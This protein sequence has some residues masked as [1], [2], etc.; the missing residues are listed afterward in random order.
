MIQGIVWIYKSNLF[1]FFG[2][3][4]FSYPMCTFDVKYLSINNETMAEVEKKNIKNFSIPISSEVSSDSHRLYAILHYLRMYCIDT[5][6]IAF[7]KP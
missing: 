1:A 5:E 4:F 6:A 2:N 7:K 3:S